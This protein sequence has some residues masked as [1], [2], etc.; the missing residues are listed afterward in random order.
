MS[1]RK[2]DFIETRL[3][4][5]RTARQARADYQSARANGSKDPGRW[6][7]RNLTYLAGKAFRSVRESA[8][9][10][11]EQAKG[12]LKQLRKEGVERPSKWHAQR[13]TP[14][15]SRIEVSGRRPIRSLDA[16]LDAVQFAWGEDVPYADDRLS[17]YPDTPGRPGYRIEEYA[18]SGGG[19]TGSVGDDG[20]EDGES[21]E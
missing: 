11:K 5:G 6:A 12:E 21:D 13:M 18:S 15:T 2:Q 20:E 19:S 10:T 14:V 16:Y 8:G 9:A 17:Y 7:A 1:S 4:M 3:S